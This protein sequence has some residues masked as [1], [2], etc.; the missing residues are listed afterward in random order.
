MSFDVDPRDNRQEFACEC[1]GDIS[2]SNGK[3]ECNT[4]E[5]VRYKQEFEVEE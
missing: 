4:C 3:W 5:F 1:G 2:F